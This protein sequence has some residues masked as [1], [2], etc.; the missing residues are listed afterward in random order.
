MYNQILK[1]INNQCASSKSITI[2]MAQVWL[3][4]FNATLSTIFQLYCGGLQQ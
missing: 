2:K 1:K 3:M 4:V